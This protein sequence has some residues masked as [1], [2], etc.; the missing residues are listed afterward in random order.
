MK[1]LFIVHG[2]A[3]LGCLLPR[4]VA[5]LS[6]LPLA[7]LA[8]RDQECARCFIRPKMSCL[9]KPLQF[10]L[11]ERN[12]LSRQTRFTAMLPCPEE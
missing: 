4:R 9:I 6:K 1:W 10:R 8:L 5:V 2:R 7:L 3:K 11:L 12:K